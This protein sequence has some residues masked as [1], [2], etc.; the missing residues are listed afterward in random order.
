[1]M[2][3]EVL[4]SDTGAGLAGV[5]RRYEDQGKGGA[6]RVARGP[7]APLQL[8]AQTCSARAC[9]E[10]LGAEPHPIHESRGVDLGLVQAGTVRRPHPVC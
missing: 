7:Q 6:P 8:L 2:A 5:G 10:I 1:M 4:S 9:A 3:M